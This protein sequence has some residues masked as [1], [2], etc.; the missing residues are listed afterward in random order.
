M[1]YVAYFLLATPVEFLVWL[2]IGRP[3]QTG[4]LVFL[5]CGSYFEAAVILAYVAVVRAKGNRRA[6][7]EGA[8][9]RRTLLVLGGIVG[10]LIASLLWWC[11]FSWVLRRFP[12]AQPWSKGYHPGQFGTVITYYLF[13]SIFIVFYLTIV[14]ADLPYRNLKDDRLASWALP[15]TAESAGDFVWTS[16]VTWLVLYRLS[17]WI[18]LAV[19]LISG[20]SGASLD[21]SYVNFLSSIATFIACVPVS[22]WLCR[23]QPKTRR[24]SIIVSQ[25]ASFVIPILATPLL[26]PGAFLMFVP[27]GFCLQTLN[28]A[29][30]V[31]GWIVGD[32][33]WR[34][35]EQ[36]KLLTA[37]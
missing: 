5:N 16:S 37:K 3:A 12:G 10:G 20:A 32:L 13:F 6:G 4:W 34:S 31:W 35:L 7:S 2:V 28:A 27:I 33:R 8:V 17:E 36:Q 14:A 21:V 25:I 1:I 23:R 18:I 26:V 22:L 30:F 19:L 15:G 29:G 24:S 11:F 9:R